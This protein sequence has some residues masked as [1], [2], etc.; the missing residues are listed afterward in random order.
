MLDTLLSAGDC[1]GCPGASDVIVLARRDEPRLIYYCPHCGQ[2][3]RCEGRFDPDAD[4]FPLEELAPRGVRLP[5]K[6]ET[7]ELPGVAP[8]TYAEVWRHDLEPLLE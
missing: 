7:A 5:T 6:Q 4:P 8:H 3:W 1:P 2:S